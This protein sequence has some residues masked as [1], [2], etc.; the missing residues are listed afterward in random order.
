MTMTSTYEETGTML[1]RL[2]LGTMWI[3]HALLKWFVFSIDGFAAF[4]ESQGLPS[5]M[6]W[7]VFLLELAGGIMI[8]LGLYGRF[9][10]AILL[11]IL[12]VATWTHSANGWLHTSEGGGWEYPAFLAI[13]SVVHVLL[14]DGRFSLSHRIASQA[15]EECAV[16]GAFTKPQCN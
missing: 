15:K 6:A 12:L 2:A 8:L 16:Q 13:A 3:A 1:L 10:S 11:P 14:G 9:V 5:F 7:P 4:L